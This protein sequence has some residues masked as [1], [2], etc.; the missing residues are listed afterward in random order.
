LDSKWI[1]RL[2]AGTPGFIFFI[3]GVA[4]LIGGGVDGGIAGA[5][6]VIFSVIYL[7]IWGF[8]VF[9]TYS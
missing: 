5:M 1:P 6:L 2:V 9:L 7:A 8:I 4:Y 3:L